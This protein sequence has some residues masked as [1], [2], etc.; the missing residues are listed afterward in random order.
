M[1]EKVCATVGCN[2][3]ARWMAIVEGNALGAKAPE[4]CTECCDAIAWHTLAPLALENVWQLK[5]WSDLPKDYRS[6]MDGKRMILTMS[7]R[8]ATVL[9]PWYGPVKG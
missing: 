6:R 4:R 5:K 3:P 9:A 7:M 2:N 1:A 8:G